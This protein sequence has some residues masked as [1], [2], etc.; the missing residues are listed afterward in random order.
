MPTNS[1]APCIV[2]YVTVNGRS[3]RPSLQGFVDTSQCHVHESLAHVA[4]DK[5]AITPPMSQVSKSW[6]LTLSRRQG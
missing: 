2:D 6:P 1:G 3:Y 4:C 5:P